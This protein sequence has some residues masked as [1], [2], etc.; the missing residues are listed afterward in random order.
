LGNSGKRTARETFVQQLTGEFTRKLV[1]IVVSV[2][3][4]ALGGVYLGYRKVAHGLPRLAEQ[5]EQQKI[6]LARLSTDLQVSRDRLDH[7][8]SKITDLITQLKAYDQWTACLETEE[9]T[10]RDYT[11]IWNTLGCVEKLP[12]SP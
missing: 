11:F 1:A 10:G 9:K 2:T 8:E 6:Q 3:L 7:A 5:I 4:S 12:K